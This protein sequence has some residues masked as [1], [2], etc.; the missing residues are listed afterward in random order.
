MGAD[1]HWVAVPPDRDERPVQCFGAFTADLYALAEWLRQCQVET[2][3]M[4]STGVSWMALFEVLEERGFD[5]KLVDPHAVRQVPGRKTDVKDCQWLQELHTSGLLRGAF[6]PEDEVCVLRSYLRQ[7]SMLVTMAARTVQHMQK[8]LE[9]MHLKL[10]EV[11]SDITGKT[12]MTILR[13]ILAG[14]RDPQRLAAYRD[15]RCTHDHATIAKALTG[16][17]RAEHLCALQQAVDQYDVLAQQLRACDGHIEGCLQT[18]VPDV[19]VDAPPSPPVRAWRSSRSN[20][21]SF[22]VQTSL[23]A[24]TGVD[25]T[26]IDGIESLTALKV[27]SEIGLD[28]TRWP[29]S[30][31]CAS[32]LGLCPGNKVSGGKRDRIRSKPSANRAA[33]ALRLAAQGVANSHSAL[34]AYYRRMRARLGA[35]KAMTATAHKLARLVY[36]MLRYGTAYVDAGQQA[37][38]QK[39]R[40]RVLTNLQRKAKAFGYKLVHVEDLDGGVASPL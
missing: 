16:H 32:W 1:A 20:P 39:Y 5:V 19:E 17:W 13:A 33:T 26:Q 14:E 36:S 21:L 34:G 28:M 31:H 18:F 25:L 38:E 15:K 30:K 8:A 23:E 22:D 4:E 24:M 12:G 35:P 37:Y 6:R 2:V 9:Q 27:V 40:D 29:T 10:T 3:V 11:V 7:R